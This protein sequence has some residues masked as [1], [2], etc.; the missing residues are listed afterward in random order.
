MKN[1]KIEEY[2]KEEEFNHV[3]NIYTE[4]LN[5]FYKTITKIGKALAKNILEN[6]IDGAITIINNL[7]IL[8]KDKEK[9]KK[10]KKVIEISNDDASFTTDDYQILMFLIFYYKDYE[11]IKYFVL[12]KPNGVKV[13]KDA[14]EEVLDYYLK[15]PKNNP[16]INYYEKILELFLYNMKPQDLT[17]NKGKYLQ[18]INKSP[19]KNSWHIKKI[20]NIIEMSD[21]VTIKELGK[22]YRIKYH[23][24]QHVIE[25]I[26]SIYQNLDNRVDLTQ[27]NAITIDG[28]KTNLFDDAFYVLELP[29]GNYKLYIHIVDIPSYIKKTSNINNEAYLRGE[30]LY[31]QDCIVPMIPDEITTFMCSL[32]KNSIKNAITYEINLDSNFDFIGN[33]ILDYLKI[34]KSLICIKENYSYQ[35]ADRL[36]KDENGNNILFN[37]YLITD[38]LKRENASKEIYRN[39]QNRL[40]RLNYSVEPK[41]STMN[42]LSASIIQEL[43]ILVNHLTA[44]YFTHIDMPFMYRNSKRLS[45]EELNDKLKMYY[46][47][48]NSNKFHLNELNS[49]N[50]RNIA[51]I[52]SRTAYYSIDNEG[53]FGLNMDTYSHSSSPM[54][55]Y[56]DIISQRLIYDFIFNNYLNNSLIYKWEEEIEETSKHLNE[57]E[58]DNEMFEAEYNFLI[59]R[60]ILKNIK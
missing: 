3:D 47:Y 35:W 20:F 57:K 31:L 10:I 28:A 58:S 43:M 19:C 15:L 2:L 14:L 60:K 45:K 44:E 33:N 50:V 17:K 11:L 8:V 32:N 54:R 48:I 1:K 23:F 41:E 30:T 34:Y 24:P 55:R 26:P 13:F 53:H 4:L 6:D 46:D 40:D 37:A 7:S 38:K 42:N 39:I 59:K 29:N 18:M 12:S 36:I 56:A 51:D 49:S 21:H 25:E 27:Q 52:L 22:K 16:D 5:N 9:I